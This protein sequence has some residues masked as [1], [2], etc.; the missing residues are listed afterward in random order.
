MSAA[1]FAGVPRRLHTF[2][3]QIWITRHGINRIIFKGFDWLIVQFTSLIFADSNSQRQFLIQEKVCK[4]NKISLLGY[5]SISGVDLERFTPN[6]KLRRQLRKELLVAEDVCVFLFVGRLCR[7]KG[8]FDLVSAFDDLRANHQNTALWIV[9]PDEENIQRQ[10]QEHSPE[11]YR[12]ITWIGPS[13]SP[14]NYMAA[15]DVLV[16]PSYREGFGSVIIEAAACNLP[17]I[18]YRI[19]G[20]IDAVVDGET[21]SLVEA[22]DITGLIQEMR[23]FC[24]DSKMRASLAAAARSRACEKFSN[25]SITLAWLSFYEKLL[26]TTYP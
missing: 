1:F 8:I 25:L 22:G 3:G 24:D 12:L 11:I 16:L 15:A 7:D 26:S 20:V 4:P 13:F 21:G 10:I 23:K 19:D 2:T 9:G 14:E 5:G 6:D 18:A 17:T